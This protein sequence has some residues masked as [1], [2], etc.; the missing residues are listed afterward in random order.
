MTIDILLPVVM[1]QVTIKN[2]ST[3]HDQRHRPMPISSGIVTGRQRRYEKDEPRAAY[4]SIGEGECVD[5]ICSRSAERHQRAGS[6][7]AL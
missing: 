2:R 4:E 1:P 3:L 6:D 5:G 7:E